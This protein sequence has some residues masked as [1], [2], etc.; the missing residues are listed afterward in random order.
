MTV[1][2]GATITTG[3]V[4]GAEGPSRPENWSSMTTTQKQNWHKKRRGKVR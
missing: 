3:G 1:V 4:A 2:G